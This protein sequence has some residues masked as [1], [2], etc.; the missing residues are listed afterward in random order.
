MHALTRSVARAAY[1]ESYRRLLL[2]RRL[3][4]QRCLSSALQDGRRDSSIAPSSFTDASPFAFLR[5]FFSPAA[6]AGAAS[7]LARAFFARFAA[8]A[9]TG[10]TAAASTS[11]GAAFTGAG[12]VDV[13]AVVVVSGG[14]QLVQLLEDACAHGA[15]HARVKHGFVAAVVLVR[16]LRN[17][18]VTDAKVRQLSR[19]S[20]VDSEF[21]RLPSMSTSYCVPQYGCGARPAVRRAGLRLLSP[22]PPCGARSVDRVVEAERGL[23]YFM[24]VRRLVERRVSNECGGE[25]G[26]AV[27]ARRVRR[28]ESGAHGDGRGSG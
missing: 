25:C 11:L 12:A 27:P 9:V 6:V 14:V 26:E 3:L 24:V 20:R 13:A 10:A 2:H 23:P 15:L 5:G 19:P 18:V 8:A 28:D 16:A 21:Q 1:A 7:S 22:C 17:L 4:R